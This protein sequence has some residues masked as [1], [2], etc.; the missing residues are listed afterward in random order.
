[1]LLPRFKPDR[2]H[3]LFF[4]AV[5][6][7]IITII[8]TYIKR[9]YVDVFNHLYC[10]VIK[11]PTLYVSHYI[12]GIIRRHVGITALNDTTYFDIW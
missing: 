7:F 5:V 1:M 2:L 11:Y 8:Q 10:N 4:T 3:T 9:D 6:Y 12:S